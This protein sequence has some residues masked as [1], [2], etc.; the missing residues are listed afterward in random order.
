MPELE[1]DDAQM[2]L[3]LYENA[4][5]GEDFGHLT[6]RPSRRTRLIVVLP[7]DAVSCDTL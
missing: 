3:H 7:G 1:P 6:S 4:D 5:P 2:H